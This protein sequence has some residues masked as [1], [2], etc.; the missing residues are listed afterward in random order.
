M[1]TRQEQRLRLASALVTHTLG[2]RFAYWFYILLIGFGFYIWLF[3]LDTILACLTKNWVVC[4]SLKKIYQF[5]LLRLSLMKSFL[6]ILIHFVHFYV[7]DQLF[8]RSQAT[9]T[10]SQW[11]LFVFVWHQT[12]TQLGCPECHNNFNAGMTF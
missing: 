12:N 6:I 3:L 11:C 5:L 10:L 9:K 8:W 4:L 1:M 2:S 7:Q